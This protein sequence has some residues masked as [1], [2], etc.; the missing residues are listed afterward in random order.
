MGE[1]KQYAVVAWAIITIISY[2]WQYLLSPMVYVS[3]SICYIDSHLCCSKQKD[4]VLKLI[5]ILL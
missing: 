3:D 1:R 2:A 5:K 4:L